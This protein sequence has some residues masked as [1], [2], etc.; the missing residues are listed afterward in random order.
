MAVTVVVAV[1]IPVDAA[2]TMVA[3]TTT[4]VDAAMITATAVATTTVVAAVAV[5]VVCSVGCSV[6]TTATVVAVVTTVVAAAVA[7]TP[8]RVVVAATKP[9]ACIQFVESRPCRRCFV[10]LAQRLDEMSAWPKSK[11]PAKLTF[12][13]CEFSKTTGRLPRLRGSGRFLFC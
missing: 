12:N 10:S 8:T 2:M 7:D 4:V 3:A 9:S 11:S 13:T 5:I 1:T 6:V